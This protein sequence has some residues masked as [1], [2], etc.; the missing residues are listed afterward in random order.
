MRYV[1]TLLVVLLVAPV[2]QGRI[3]IT[4]FGGHQGGGEFEDYNTDSELEIKEDSVYGV[5]VGLGAETGDAQLELYFSRQESELEGSGA[6]SN[7]SLF[8]LDVDYYHLGGS[9]TFDQGKLRP[10]IAASLGATRFDPKSSGADPEAKFSLGLG[11]GVK[12]FFTERIGLRLEG[13][14]F[15]TFIDNESAGFSGPNG[16]VIV[17]GH[18]DVLVQYNAVVG[19]IFVIP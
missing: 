9:F 5:M 1:T 14:V 19:L 4:P 3:E 6:F 13:R 10:F 2:S 8:E 17:V 16:G 12:W 7:A 18:S 11:G 15:G